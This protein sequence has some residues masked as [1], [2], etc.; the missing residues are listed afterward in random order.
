M[1][2]VS[3]PFLYALGA[4]GGLHMFEL[5]A[6]DGGLT[7]HSSA[8]DQDGTPFYIKGVT[9][10]G[11]EGGEDRR[12]AELTR[13][14]RPAASVGYVR[15]AQGAVPT[16]PRVL[17]VLGTRTSLGRTVRTAHLGWHRRRGETKAPPNGLMKQSLDELLAK[18]ARNKFN[19]IRLTVNHLSIQRN[20]AMND[21]GD[22]DV[23][24]N[25]WFAGNRYVSCP[26]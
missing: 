6:H 8:L 14:V 3:P 2:A 5:R 21:Y 25:P 18:L 17:Y 15:E 4:L 9:W 20:E 7:A 24:K 22:L 16:G 11:M 23:A 1:S 19:T 12:G 13:T 26:A 10:R